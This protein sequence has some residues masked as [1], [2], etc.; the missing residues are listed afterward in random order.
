MKTSIQGQ[1]KYI[2]VHITAKFKSGNCDQNCLA[3]LRSR[4]VKI[5]ET[6][7]VWNSLSEPEKAQVLLI[8]F[9]GSQIF[10][11]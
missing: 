9:Q 11:Y 10:T 3:P 6:F 2:E 7:K 1:I 5:E 4:S 8:H